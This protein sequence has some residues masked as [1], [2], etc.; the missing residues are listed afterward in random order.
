MNHEQRIQLAN[1]ITE[2]LL[3]RYKKE[4]LLGGIYGSTAKG[5]DTEYSDLEMFFVVENGSKAKSFRFAYESI[6]IDVE[7]QN[8]A[9]VEKDITKIELDWSLRMGKLF[10]L[11]I[12]HGDS[13]ILSKFRE[14]LEKVPKARFDAFLAKETPLCYEGLWKLK[15]VKVREN[16]FEEMGLFVGGILGD[17]MLLVAIFN[18]EFINHSYFDALI[19]SFSIK[20]LPKD[21][22]KNA[23]KLMKWNDLSVDETVKLVDEFVLNFVELLAE[24]AVV[25]REHSPLEEVDM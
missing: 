18:R 21:Y 23:R 13:A 14:I 11:K 2:M 6:P 3:E 19:E 24:N 16:T 5:T 7:V 15:A 25:I 22:E 17:F 10:N 20:K 4:I 1:R 9:D 12:V 8:V